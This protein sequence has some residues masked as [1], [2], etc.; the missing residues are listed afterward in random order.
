MKGG[1]GGGEIKYWENHGFFLGT[2]RFSWDLRIVF[3]ASGFYLLYGGIFFAVLPDFSWG[4]LVFWDVQIDSS[5]AAA[6]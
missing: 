4:R 2:S 3:I 5:F 1:K 6:L